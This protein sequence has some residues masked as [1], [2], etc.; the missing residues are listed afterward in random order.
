MS[1]ER[2]V[3]LS[4][5]SAT[6]AIA[7]GLVA[8]DRAGTRQNAEA[9]L[10]DNFKT[11]VATA[12]RDG[13]TPYWLGQEFEAGGQ[14]FRGPFTS[15]IG[16]EVPGGGVSTDYDALSGMSLTITSYS[17]AAWAQSSVRT[18]ALQQGATS[19]PVTSGAHDAELLRIPFHG[20][21]LGL[22]VV[23]HLGE[24]VV[25]AAT[26][27]DGSHLDATPN[28]N[29]LV[30]EPTLLSVLTQLRPYPQ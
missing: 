3:I 6:L 17:P 29:P 13:Y 26:S 14:Q 1:M 18:S 19:A 27:A 5:I 11:V 25:V 21:L 24:T 15:V 23:F 9:I 4:V 16:H 8:C 30:D 12:P 10:S 2:Y 28:P 20:R 22:T 7:V